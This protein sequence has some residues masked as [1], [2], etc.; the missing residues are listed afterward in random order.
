M[1]IALLGYGKEGQAAE[2]YFLKHN[3]DAE[4]KVYQDFTIEEISKED[5]SD[6][7]LVLRSPSVHPLPGVTSMTRY[8]R[9]YFLFLLQMCWTLT[10]ELTFS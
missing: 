10:V 1:K 8:L 9:G 3:P 2:A 6:F 7:N 4:I 5:F